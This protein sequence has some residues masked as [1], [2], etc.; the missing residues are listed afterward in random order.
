M[1]VQ[2]FVIGVKSD[3]KDDYIEVAN[4]MGALFMEFGA[5]EIVENWENEVP[6]GEQTDFRKA[7]A[8]EPDEKIVFSWAV[9]ADKASCDAAHE[10]MM[11]DERMQSMEMPDMIDG[12][13]MILGSFDQIYRASKQD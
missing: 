9:W 7:I 5:L 2:G 6:D 10:K 12:K 4:K 3:R 8:A 1:Y 13:R 11:Q